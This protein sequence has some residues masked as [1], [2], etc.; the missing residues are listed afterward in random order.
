MNNPLLLNIDS[1]SLEGPQ[2]KGT[3]ISV[4]HIVDCLTN[5]LR[6]YTISII[7][8]VY[9]LMMVTNLNL[10]LSSGKNNISKD[11]HYQ[12]IIPSRKIFYTLGES[13]LFAFLT[14]F[15]ITT[16]T[17]FKTKSTKMCLEKPDK[18]NVILSEITYPFKFH[19]V[20]ITNGSKRYLLSRC[21]R[22]IK[23]EKYLFI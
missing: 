7:S 23:R 21:L 3:V 17:L 13:G 19:K 1:I 9:F 6:A 8:F 18:L 16:K 12:S 14:Q 2:S 15:F 5:R 22:F 4:K 20:V 11:V 10:F